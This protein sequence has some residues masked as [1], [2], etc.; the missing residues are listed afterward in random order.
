M[1]Q[2]QVAK[3]LKLMMSLYCSVVIIQQMLIKIYITGIFLV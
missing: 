3:V 1:K 2:D